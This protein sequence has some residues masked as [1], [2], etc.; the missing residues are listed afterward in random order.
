M[1]KGL[2]P[3]GSL[4]EG[5]LVR[6]TLRRNSTLFRGLG[7]TL[8]TSRSQGHCPPTVYKH[9]FYKHELQAVN[10]TSSSTAANPTSLTIQ[11]A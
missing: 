8:L 5:A 3:G 4:M 11:R 10:I 2:G 1:A 9:N 7:F 6:C